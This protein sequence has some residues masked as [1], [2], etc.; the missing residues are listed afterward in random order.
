M[1]SVIMPTHRR[2]PLLHITLLSVFSQDFDDWELV[3]VDASEDTYFE[4]ALEEIFNNYWYIGKYKELVKDKIKIVRPNEGYKC[5]GKMKMDGFR[6]CTQDNDFCV[7]LDHDDMIVAH[8]LKNMSD[9]Y[10]LYPNTEMFTADYT[11]FIHNKGDVT[12]NLVSYMGGIECGKIHFLNFGDFY[13]SFENNPLIRWTNPHKWKACMTPKIISKD[14]L[15]RN[16]F[17]FVEDATIMDDALFRVMSHSL[18][19]TK[20]DM[21]AYVYVAY[22]DFVQNS[23]SNL[24]WEGELERFSKICDDYSEFLDK[25]GFVKKRNCFVPKNQ[26]T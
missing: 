15:R 19:E 4:N 24:Q 18:N 17:M 20:L 7:F 25:V 6:N 26:E 11:S 1:I 3:V 10:K 16:Q 14:A 12:S 22:F 2:M 21:V 8:L 9:A 13:Y 23:T 5:P